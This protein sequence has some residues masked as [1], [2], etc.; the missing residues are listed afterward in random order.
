MRALAIRKLLTL[1]AFSFSLGMVQLAGAGPYEDADAA[2]A[3]GDYESALILYRSLAEQGN[4]AAQYSLG[5]MYDKGQGVKR[6]RNEAMRW[7]Q[8]A[9]EQ[10]NQDAQLYLSDFH[11]H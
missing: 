7:L 6:D 5:V 11:E 2:F 1:L 10:G 8:R 9:A 3:R 4:A